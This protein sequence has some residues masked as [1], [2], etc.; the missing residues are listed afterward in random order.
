[1][2]TNQSAIL[3]EAQ[4]DWTADCSRA[5]WGLLAIFSRS[6]SA[7]ERDFS[8]SPASQDEAEYYHTTG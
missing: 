1:M 7:V 2:R 4:H 3:G 5:E 6:I 8:T